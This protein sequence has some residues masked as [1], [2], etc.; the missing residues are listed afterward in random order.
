ML[1]RIARIFA[2]ATMAIGATGCGSVVT[3]TETAGEVDVRT[4]DVAKYPVEPIDTIYEYS[5]SMRTSQLLAAYRLAG[6]MALGTDID[7]EFKY[8]AGSALTSPGIATLYLSKATREVLQD[9]KMLYGWASGSTDKVDYDV[10]S[11]R[12]ADNSISDLQRER[13]SASFSGITVLQ[14]ADDETAERAAK[15]M[16]NADFAVAAN[17]NKSISLPNYPT[18]TSHHRPGVTTLGSTLAH[19][20]YVIY[21][22][23]G[24]REDDVAQLTALAEKAY[25]TQISL[26]DKLPALSPADMLRLPPDPEGM[27]RR[28]LNPKTSPT[29]D[30]L[31]YFTLDRIGYYQANR[32]QQL[33]DS[34][35][36][37]TGAD[38]FTRSWGTE[39][40]RTRDE[41][42]AETLRDKVIELLVPSSEFADSP[43]Q[44]P[45]TKCA[46]NTD[47]RLNDKFV[48][49]GERKRFLCAVQYRRYVAIVDANQI[50]D[51]HQR[52]A[53]QFALFANSQ[54][55]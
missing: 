23:V 33:N 38:R 24:V 22:H 16:S 31:E 14:F 46:K 55:Q 53:A 27:L 4:L 47:P 25:R 8:G 37:E 54:V 3:G 2:V 10:M 48:D 39:L 7:P 32:K 49:T 5:P 17:D 18:A 29:L 11:N 35:Y 19:G 9:N 30:E 13:L 36:A 40:V 43:P 28:A 20:R 12:A 45:D 1:F 6:S 50:Q 42:A 52:A 34:L 44:L 26:L 51:A 21:I 41:E 15:D